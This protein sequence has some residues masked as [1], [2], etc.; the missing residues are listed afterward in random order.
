MIGGSAYILVLFTEHALLGRAKGASPAG[1]HP[2]DRI[3][4]PDSDLRLP[5]GSRPTLCGVVR[6]ANTSQ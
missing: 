5:Q 2:F 6:R 4:Y 3:D 1:S